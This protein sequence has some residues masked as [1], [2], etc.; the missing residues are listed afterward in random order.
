MLVLEDLII[1]CLVVLQKVYC[2]VTIVR[3]KRLIL[4]QLTKLIVVFFMKALVT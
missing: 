3:C 4:G 2:L 1:Y